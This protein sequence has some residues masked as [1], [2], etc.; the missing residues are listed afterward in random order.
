MDQ[1]KE[2]QKIARDQAL[3]QVYGPLDLDQFV[4]FFK[5]DTAYSIYYEQILPVLKSVQKYISPKLQ[6]DQSFKQV[7]EQN[8]KDMLGQTTMFDF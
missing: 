2:M 7:I 8:F 4:H 6:F 5:N 1:L 3:V